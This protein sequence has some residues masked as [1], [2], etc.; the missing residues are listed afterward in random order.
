MSGFCWRTLYVIFLCI[1]IVLK[2][3]K[4]NLK[5]YTKCKKKPV[6]PLELGWYIRNSACRF[7]CYTHNLKIIE[8]GIREAAKAAGNC[9]SPVITSYISWFF[10]LYIKLIW[11]WVG[12]LYRNGAEIG[13][14]FDKNANKSFFI[15]EKIKNTA[16]AQLWS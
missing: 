6:L 11:L 4:L 15:F 9:A 12:F 2:F 14:L 7:A 16:S 10:A 1:V 3:E 13:Y 5:I 8:D